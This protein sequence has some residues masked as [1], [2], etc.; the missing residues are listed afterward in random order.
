MASQNGIRI[1]VVDDDALVCR[2]LCEVLSFEGYG[3]SSVE[4]AAQ[5]LE[6][7]KETPY[8]VV[9]SDMKMPRMSGLD[10]LKAIRA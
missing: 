9:I 6:R 1:L 2:S 3:C 5:A 10:L 7:L 8:D 4:D